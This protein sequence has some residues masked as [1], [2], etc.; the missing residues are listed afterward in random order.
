MKICHLTK[1]RLQFNSILCQYSELTLTSLTLLLLLT[2]L[3][4]MNIISVK[5]KFKNCK[6]HYNG[7]RITVS[8]C[9]LY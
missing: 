1:I 9:K 7:K 2:L 4:E 3:L 6:E 5:K 8:H